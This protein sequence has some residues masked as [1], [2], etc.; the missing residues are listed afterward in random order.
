RDL[1]EVAQAGV[2]RV[3]QRSELAQIV[4]RERAHGR[5]HARVLLEYVAR[6]PVERGRQPCEHLRLELPQARDR[7][8]RAGLLALAAA[9]VVARP[10]VGVAL[11]RVERD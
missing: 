1:V 5:L 7:Q 11:A 2:T 9:V 3:E 6:G 4:A 10:A 8:R